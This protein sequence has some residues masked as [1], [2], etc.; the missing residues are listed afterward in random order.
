MDENENL[1]YV[2]EKAF[3]EYSQKKKSK[4]KK[5]IITFSVIFGILICGYFSMVYICTKVYNPGTVI[6]G[7]DM[8]F[9]SVDSAE[10]LVGEKY[11]TYEMTIKYRDGE[12]KVK[13][14]DIGARVDIR[15]SLED[16]KAG[17]NPFM[18]FRFD[19]VTEYK[20]EKVISYDS[21]AY[22]R[23]KLENMRLDEMLME[24]P[25]N[26][27]IKLIDGR[28]EA[29]PGNP[30]TKIDIELFDKQ[31][32]KHFEAMDSKFDVESDGCYVKSWLSVDSNSVKSCVEKANGMLHAEVTYLYGDTEV[33]V[34]TSDDIADLIRIDK[35]YR[36]TLDRNMI[37]KIVSDFAETHDTY[38]K[39]RQFKTHD[40]KIVTIPA[41]EYGWE[42]NTEG[43]PEQIYSDIW[44]RASV[45]REPEFLH[46]GYTYSVGNGGVDDV[47]NT[48]AEAD[49]TN[50]K[51]YLYVHGEKILETDCVSGKV[52]AG[53]STPAGLYQINIHQRNAILRGGEEPVPVDYWMRFVRG[54][55]FHDAT[56][57]YS[58]GGDIYYANGSHG[59]INLPYDAAKTMFY[60]TEI[61][62]PVIVYWR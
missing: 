15:N 48:Y 47:G 9:K 55:G 59:C 1:V 39:E 36:I 54:I 45:T 5:L 26:P 2:D 60:N 50:Q 33:P 30:G 18:W 8:S 22:D 35:G 44:S 3:A 49:L 16:I 46:R 27:E 32:K 37:R 41:T 57:R 34:V 6:D 42:L 43:E 23:F 14:A 20:A 21:A 7:M 17:Q 10:N 24:E 53:M 31:L 38:N 40:N 56:W 19:K 61:G 11:R 51:V 12:E 28:Y 29:V 52:T 25:E 4:K 58:F 13:A 62:T